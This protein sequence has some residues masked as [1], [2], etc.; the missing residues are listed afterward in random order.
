MTWKWEKVKESHF[1]LQFPTRAT[2]REHTGGGASVGKEMGDP[3]G[4]VKK[5]GLNA[6]N[7]SSGELSGLEKKDL[8]P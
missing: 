6:V 7:L 4:D 8:T 2:E 3:S 5:T 1:I